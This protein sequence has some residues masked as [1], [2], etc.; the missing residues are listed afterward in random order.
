M[1]ELVLKL[2]KRL[3]VGHKHD[4]RCVYDEQAKQELILAC[5]LLLIGRRVGFT[6]DSGAT[7]QAV[8]VG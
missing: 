4:G 2:A 6:A 7:V 5:G 1:S 8:A 3:I